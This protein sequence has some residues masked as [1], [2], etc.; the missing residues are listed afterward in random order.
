MDRV[1]LVMRQNRQSAWSFRFY[2]AKRARFAGRRRLCGTRSPKRIS[3]HAHVGQLRN[4]RVKKDHWYTPRAGHWLVRSYGFRAYAKPRQ[5]TS[6]NAP[7]FNVANLTGREWSEM[8]KGGAY[9]SHGTKKRRKENNKT[10]SDDLAAGLLQF[11]FCCE[12]KQSDRADKHP[13]H[14]KPRGILKPADDKTLAQNLMMLLRECISQ[15]D[16]DSTVAQK[17]KSSLGQ[18]TRERPFQAQRAVQW[19]LDNKEQDSPDASAQP[20]K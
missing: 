3:F 18:W 2:L 5:D 13:P 4:H 14:K 9:G 19:N 6:R 10:Q 1:N 20:G 16:K 12:N 8:F 15:G 7:T 11:L 17:I